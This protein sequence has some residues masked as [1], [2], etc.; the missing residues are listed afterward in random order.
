MAVK[1]QRAE[2]LE[3]SWGLT[4]A[5]ERAS[6]PTARRLRPMRTAAIQSASV[7]AAPSR[8]PD[9]RACSA[10]CSLDRIH[11]AC[12]LYSRSIAVKSQKEHVHGMWMMPA[13]KAYVSHKCISSYILRMAMHEPHFSLL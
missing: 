3:S 5:S 9:L 2:P 1:E 4:V 6:A 10:S 12:F 13:G 7:P 8:V 11:S